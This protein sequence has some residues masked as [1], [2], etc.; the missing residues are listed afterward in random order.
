MVVP[1][2]ILF[3]LVK[4]QIGQ[5]SSK[6]GRFVGIPFMSTFIVTFI[7]LVIVT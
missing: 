5:G 1:V 4:R 7:I 6:S 2:G 3:A